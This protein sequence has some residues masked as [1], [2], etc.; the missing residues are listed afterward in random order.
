MTEQ[1]QKDEWPSFAEELGRKGLEALGKWVAAHEAGKISKREL[2]LVCEA[3]Y[4]TMSGLASWKDTDL[5]IAVQE[6]LKK[7]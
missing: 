6:E 2:Y 5:V 7:K 3:L 1:A 4:A